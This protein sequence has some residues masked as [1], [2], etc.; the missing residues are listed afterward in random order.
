[1]AGPAAAQATH[2][3]VVGAGQ[4][5]LAVSHLL[6][7]RGIDHVVL[8]RG[9]TAQ[10]WRSRWDSLRLL[11]PNWLTRLPGYRYDGPDQEGFMTAAGVAGFLEEYAGRSGAPVVESA[12]V[13]AVSRS[14]DRFHLASTAG[15]WSA[16]AVVVA[17]GHCQL[18]RVP[19]M[20]SHLSPD[21]VQVDSAGYRRPS[22]LPAGGVLVVG[23]SATGVQLADELAEA[24][25]DVVLAVGS[26]TRIPRRYRGMDSV[27]WLDRMG[28]LGRRLDD[29][30]AG[31]V[32][33]HEPSLQLVGRP[34]R[35]DVDLGS[36]QRR[37][38]R[39]AGR[40]T[41]LHRH[42]ARFA[43]DLGESVAVADGRLDRL[44]ERIDEHV[45]ASGLDAEVLPVTRTPHVRPS[46]PVRRSIHLR[47]A[48]IGSVV[49]AVGYRRAYPWLRLP[50]TD[51]GG[52]I[53]HRHGV[54]PMPGLYVVGMSWQVGRSSTLIDGVGRDARLVVDHLS[55]RM[56]ATSRAGA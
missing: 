20:A 42:R 6:T 37:G 1:M 52:D 9:R 18:P 22:D 43:D 47:A 50:V 32:R 26:H 27:W 17:T 34:D 49:W 21:V 30:P 2:T 35:R 19:A 56:G 44:L 11:T 53:R 51:A 8:E 36:L 55:C 5:G 29:L 12:E 4:A 38:V 14:A 7:E 24:G 54:T 25:R 28:I 31:R 33:T 41:G 15:S 13:L 23:A 39:L 3:V 46:N 16:H 48:G 40:L 10:S 45:T